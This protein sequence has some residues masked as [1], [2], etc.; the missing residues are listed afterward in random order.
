[1]SED[2]NNKGP[3]TASM[4]PWIVWMSII[5]LV[6]I[7]LSYSKTASRQP[8]ELRYD[9]FVAKATNSPSLVFDGKIKPKQNGLF[10]IT[11][12]FVKDQQMTTN[13][14][15][16][17]SFSGRG[18]PLKGQPF[19][20]ET[21]VPEVSLQPLLMTGKFES[22]PENTL[23]MSFLFTSLST[24]LFRFSTPLSTKISGVIEKPRLFCEFRIALSINLEVKTPPYSK[25][26]A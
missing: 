3:S 8:A 7:F 10:E 23:L 4:R 6:V 21:L 5:V 26:V 16:V 2:K 1:M 11:G 13:E 24:C 9:D 15:G 20:I 22:V 14:Q 25:E 17:V 19:R 18:R 12:F